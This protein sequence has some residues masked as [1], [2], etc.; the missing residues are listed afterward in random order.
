[1]A[2]IQSQRELV[3]TSFFD[4]LLIDDEYGQ[5][6][7]P[8]LSQAGSEEIG[9]FALPCFGG[10]LWEPKIQFLAHKSA[11]AGVRYVAFG[12]SGLDTSDKGIEDFDVRRWVNEGI[13][14]FLEKTEG[15]QIVVAP[16]FAVTQGLILAQRY[17]DRV[18][19]LV[20]VGG[21]TSLDDH[22]VTP[23]IGIEGK[24][25][26]SYETKGYFNYPAQIYSSDGTGS[27][28]NKRIKITAENIAAARPLEVGSADEVP[29]PCPVV[30]IHCK[31]DK[32]VPHEA[33]VDLCKRIV[34]PHS[35]KLIIT[36]DF[37]HFHRKP[38]ALSHLWHHTNE[39]RKLATN[40]K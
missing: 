8:C 5:R 35:P 7:V 22:L 28:S 20:T 40:H 25:R 38:K 1:M 16:S 34:S 39:L 32:L 13:A 4:T 18:R 30:L 21:G 23:V 36:T 10:N 27:F 37:G 24:H 9:I 33:G 31:D 29:V 19:G 11:A 12:Y 2:G 6:D 14:V 17:P 3:T 26:R 15:P